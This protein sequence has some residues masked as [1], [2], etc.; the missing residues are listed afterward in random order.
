MG[1]VKVKK[2]DVWID[3]TPMSDVMTLLL[4]FF[5][6]TS[7]FIKNEPVRVNV[8]GTVS[9]TKVPET[10]TLSI[11]V[12]PEKVNGEA[13]G[14]GMVFLG[15]SNASQ[16]GQMLDDMLPGTD[17]LQ[18]NV[19]ESEA[20]FGVPLS[21]MKTYLSLDQASRSEI[22]QG[23]NPKIK[24]GIPLDSIDGGMSEFQQWV[25]AAL[26]ANTDVQLVIKSDKDTPYKTIKKVM[27]E[28]QDMGESHYYM[29]TQ[30]DG[31]K[32]LSARSYI[33]NLGGE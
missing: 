24:A 29:A 19:F 13:T 16:L 17:P 9:E 27:S 33:E 6:L 10:N 2:S 25:T 5:M 31:G 11:T 4:T 15:M 30:L 20:Q 3:M 26:V 32:V 7:T 18:K 22:L 23:N 28:L 14:N 12:S 1:K 8:P 21:S